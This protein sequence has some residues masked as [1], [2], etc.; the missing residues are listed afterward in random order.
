MKTTLPFPTSQ[1]APTLTL[2][3][4]LLWH[5]G[6]FAQAQATPP[7][8]AVEPR[9]VMLQNS[10]RLEEKISDTERKKSPI[11]VTGQ[12]IKARQDIDLLIQGDTI[13]RKQGLVIRSDR[14]EYDQSQETLKAEGRVRISREG[15]LFEGPSLSLNLDSFQGK[16][17]QPQFQLLKGVGQ[18][19]ASDRAWVQCR[20]S[21]R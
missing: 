4:M 21:V 10:P 11:H 2:C 13:L 12:G 5:G 3:G 16:F 14:I 18:G 20:Q 17:L 6:S 1:L 8:V 9:G 7:T 19:S 15:N